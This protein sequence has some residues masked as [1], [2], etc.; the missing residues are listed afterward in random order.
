[1]FDSKARRRSKFFCGR[2]ALATELFFDFYF[3]EVYFLFILKLR[4]LKIQA[5]FLCCENERH[6]SHEIGTNMALCLI[7][8]SVRN[9]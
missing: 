5:K 7:Y 6:I 3:F 9:T 8:L 4:T 2:E 1:M